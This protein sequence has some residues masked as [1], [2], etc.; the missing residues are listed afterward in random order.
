MD[1]QRAPRGTILIIEDDEAVAEMLDEILETSGFRTEHVLNGA[2]ARTSV[3]NSP[4]DLIIL[5]LMLP[6][7]DGL[8]LCS[9]LKTTSDV[10]IIV[11][12]AT[13]RK[14]DSIVAL[15]LGADD[16]I[17]KPF[18]VDNL[19]ARVE[20]VLRR[21]ERGRAATPAVVPSTDP[22]DE[23]RIGALVVDAHQRRV[24]LGGQPLWLT[25]TEYRL[26]SALMRR[27]GQVLTREELAHIVWG[28]EEA[29]MGRTI[30]V[31]I[32]RLRVKLSS[33]PVA[34]PPI[35]SVRGFGYK[36]AEEGSSSGE[37]SSAA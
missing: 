34:A 3:E 24:S 7:V 20:V 2:Q 5:D 18:D 23:L 16:F 6:D 13:T 37:A 1:N 12:S 27:P 21:S 15:R 30:D 29:S 9:T 31:H 28:Y 25:P 33:G 11:C 4:P 35:S 19:L 36:I 8:V 14:R 17:A 32:R 10:P 22:Q 26:L